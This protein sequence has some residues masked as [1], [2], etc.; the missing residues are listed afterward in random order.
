[1]AA[2]IAGFTET[3]NQTQNSLKTQSHAE[4][5]CDLESLDRP[6]QTTLTPLKN[7]FENRV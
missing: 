7:P 1:M 6:D 2:E 3:E 5:H 4:H